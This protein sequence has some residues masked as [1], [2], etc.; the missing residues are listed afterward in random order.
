MTDRDL[1]Q[2][3]EEPEAFDREQKA[4]SK[5]VDIKASAD[6]LLQTFNRTRSRGSL[7]SSEGASLCRS[8]Y[9]FRPSMPV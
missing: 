7:G 9:A 2:W 6:A 1:G 5:Q 3:N 8:L 4:A